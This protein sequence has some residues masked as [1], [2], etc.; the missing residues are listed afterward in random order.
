MASVHRFYTVVV[1]V[2]LA[3][4]DNVAIGLVPP[5]YSPISTQFG[6]PESAIALVTALSYLVTA[7]VAVGW[8]YVGDRANRKLLLMAGTLLWA[9]GTAGSAL[10]SGYAAFLAMQ[11]V[12]AFGLGAVGSVGFSVVSDLISPKRRGLVMSLFGLSQGV[13][14]LAGTLLGGQLGA[15]NWRRPFEVLAVV[16]VAA[17]VAYL[18][19][20]DIRRGQSEPELAGLFA[21]G[22]EYEYRISRA[23]LPRILARRSNVWLVLQ[24]LTAQVTFGSLVWL[25][26]LI[27]AKAQAQGYPVKTAIQVGS[28]FATLFMLGGVLSI[29]GGLV[30]DRLQRRTPRGR[31]LVAAVGILA[32]IPFYVILFFLPLHL[33][34]AK[35][36]GTGGIAGAVLAS[37]VT[38]PTVA[39][40]FLCALLALALTSANSPN[41]FALLADVNP[42]EH[43]GTVYSLGNL[44]NG[45]GRAA[46][47]G[48]VGA[49]FQA[50][51]RALPPPVNYATGL[52]LFQVFFVPTGIMY[53]RA[54]R[55]VPGDIETVREVLRERAHRDRDDAAEPART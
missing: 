45:V 19:T 34:V 15:G 7:V 37:V 17:T 6:V 35:D 12:A 8:A 29:F 42:P 51:A 36:A 24:G 1:F 49:V 55:T 9:A 14:T 39:V 27:Q 44:A 11:M 10:V 43:R 20:Y 54:S 18:F 32:G 46:G 23:D 25:P 52:A 22:G 2:I 53:W 16:G 50:L 47:N 31:A 38:E 4:L 40:S 21:A 41:W 30:G 48:L 13:G 28:M 26:R 3:S 5:L 33:T